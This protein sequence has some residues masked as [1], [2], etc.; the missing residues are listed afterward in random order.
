M[1]AHGR[2]THDA[3]DGRQVP[4]EEERRVGAPNDVMTSQQRIWM[5]SQENEKKMMMIKM[6]K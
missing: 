1:L 4:A 6:K 2:R 3:G 5:S